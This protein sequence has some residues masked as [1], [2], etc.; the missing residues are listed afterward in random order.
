MLAL[1]GVRHIVHV[2]RIRVNNNT[3]HYYK[4][5]NLAQYNIADYYYF[6]CLFCGFGTWSLMREEHRLR[7]FENRML[8]RVIG[9]QTDEVTK[10]WRRLH[11]DQLNDQ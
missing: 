7:V 5:G 11:N 4:T 2:S 10:E 1:V 9:P 8:R 3:N 6:A